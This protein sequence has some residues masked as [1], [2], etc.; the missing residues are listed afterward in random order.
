MRFSF[1]FLDYT[2]FGE[3]HLNKKHEGEKLYDKMKPKWEAIYPHGTVI[4]IN[5]Q[6]KEVDGWGKSIEE[7]Y[8][9]AISKGNAKRFYFR[10]IGMNYLEIL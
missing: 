7:S 8:Q 4:A 3:F 10:R 5:M 2:F 9:R 6:T 1:K